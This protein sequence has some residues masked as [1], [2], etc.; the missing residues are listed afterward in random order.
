L[1]TLFV[2]YAFA[3]VGHFYFEHNRPATFIYP[4]FSLMGDFKM[5]FGIL[6]GQ[7]GGIF[8]K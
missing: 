7:I 5:F 8:H 2:G 6:T 3:W 1:A 4:T